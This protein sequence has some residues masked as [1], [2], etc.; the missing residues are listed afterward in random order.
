MAAIIQDA[1]G[2]IL[3]IRR[4]KEPAKGKLSLPGGFVNPGESVEEGLRRETKEEVNLEIVSATF[5]C[6]AP[7]EYKY[8]GI[9]YPVTDFFFSARVHTLDRMA[10][11]ETEVAGIQFLEFSEET[12]QELAFPSLKLAL[13]RFS[14]S[15]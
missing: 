7:N 11:Q 4:K 5:I 13:T 3:F 10:P 14:N 2:Q 6:S 9:I 12:A 15:S 1:Q 8:R